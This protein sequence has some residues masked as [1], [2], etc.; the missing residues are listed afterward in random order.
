L[1]AI[2][3]TAGRWLLP[4]M[5]PAVSFL[6][7]TVVA[8]LLIATALRLAIRTRQQL[9]RESEHT[10]ESLRT[11]LTF[12]EQQR[13]CLRSILD[14][15]AGGLVITGADSRVQFI[16]S[17]ARRL[18]GLDQRLVGRMADISRDP[19]IHQAFATVLGQ[20]RQIETRV[21]AR[22]GQ[23]NNQGKRVLRLYAAPLR[24]NEKQIDGVV[25]TF[26]DITQLEKLE[27][28]RQEFLTNVSHE[29]RTPLSSISAFVETLLSGGLEDR[30]NSVRFLQTIQRNAERMRDLVSDIAELSAIESGAVQLRLEQ[31]PLGRLVDEVF[32]ALGPRCHKL[33]VQLCNE[34]TEACHVIADRR[35]LEQI[36]TNLADNAIKFNRPDGKVVITASAAEDDSQILISVRDTGTGIPAHDLPRVFE[37]FYRVDKARSRDLGGTGLGL[38]IVKHLAR[39]HGGEV[40]VTSEA[41]TGSEFVIKLPA[42]VA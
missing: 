3:E 31:F 33:R 11:E 15:V 21:E 18:L 16:N 4:R 6:I 36:L 2:Y 39:A 34:V 24:L 9:L 22:D 25:G 8:T 38:A 17:N 32:L 19:Q 10:L 20:G 28:I 7:T 40:S 26:I 42:R 5:N 41:G 13:D 29:L 12:T 27:R 14:S 1:L 37:R 35:R 23:G 30:E